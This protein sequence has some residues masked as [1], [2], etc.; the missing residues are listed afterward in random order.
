MGWKLRALFHS[1][2]H[3]RGQQHPYLTNKETMAQNDNI[4]G[5]RFHS[6]LAAKPN[7]ARFKVDCLMPIL[8]TSVADVILHILQASLCCL[9]SFFLDSKM[10]TGKSPYQLN[11]FIFGKYTEVHAEAKSDPL[12]IPSF[13]K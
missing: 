4:N 2:N 12:F 13:V 10:R 5:P 6:Q 7:S 11:G 1:Y 3:L 8:S 9:P